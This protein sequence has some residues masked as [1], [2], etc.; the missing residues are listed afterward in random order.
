MKHKNHWI[1]VD[2]CLAGFHLLLHALDLD[3]LHTL[4]Q[5]CRAWSL[6]AA[7]GEQ[8]HR[9]NAHKATT[10]QQA[11][12]TRTGTST[13]RKRTETTMPPPKAT[14]ATNEYQNDQPTE[15]HAEKQATQL[16]DRSNKQ[17]ANNDQPANN[18]QTKT[19]N[20]KTRTEPERNKNSQTKLFFLTLLA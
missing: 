5:S 3:L 9:Q 14:D 11:T 4:A 12:G 7:T 19:T 2:T 20:N 17:S 6:D 10:T 16:T 18:S 15:P 1:Q 8:I 13:K